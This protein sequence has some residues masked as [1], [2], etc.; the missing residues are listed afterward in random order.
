MDSTDILFRCPHPPV[1][2]LGQPASPQSPVGDLQQNRPVAPPHVQMGNPPA[3]ISQS[4]SSQ[5]IVSQIGQPIVSNAPAGNQEF[6]SPATFG[7]SVIP[8]TQ[9]LAP[10]ISFG[11]SS[12]VMSSPAT[13]PVTQ[14][15]PAV[16]PQGMMGNVVNSGAGE[17]DFADFQAAEPAPVQ[18]PKS[19]ML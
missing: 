14:L 19:G 15:P 9:H 8:G 6:A 5:S 13:L 12:S 18:A 3:P 7:T 11:G 2:F 10:N 17:D 16:L 4:H 1:P